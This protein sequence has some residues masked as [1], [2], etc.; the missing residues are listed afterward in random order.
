MSLTVNDEFPY[1]SIIVFSITSYSMKY[2]FE[3]DRYKRGIGGH[4]NDKRMF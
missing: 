1:S 4:L 3:W 2:G